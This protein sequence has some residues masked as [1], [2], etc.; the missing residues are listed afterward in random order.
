MSRT[1][2]P[3]ITAA[4]LATSSPKVVLS[5]LTINHAS[6]ASPIYVVN[7]NVAITRGGI[8]YT[9]F[10]FRVDLPVDRDGEIG[11]ARLVIDGVNQA[12]V[13][14]IRSITTAAT[15]NMVIALA[16]DPDTTEED[17]GTFQW[18]NISYDARSVSGSLTYE[19]RL[20]VIVPCDHFTPV[21]VPGNF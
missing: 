3:A 13:I 17:L 9:P 20:D 15:V 5:F 8:S 21:S 7:N 16:D 1:L 4:S 18:K 6:L 14:A 11:D 10:A 2:H 12:I 19:D